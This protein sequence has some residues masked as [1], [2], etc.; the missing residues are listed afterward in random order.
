MVCCRIIHPDTA[1]VRR[2]TVAKPKQSRKK[3]RKASP[4]Q[5]QAA[6]SGKQPKPSPDGQQPSPADSKRPVLRFV[7]LFALVLVV[8]YGLLSIPFIE[9]QA[10]PAYLRVNAS[11][12]SAVLNVFGENSTAAG[13]SITSPRFSVDVRKGCDAI[14]PSAIFAAAVLASP[15]IFRTKVPGLVVGVLLLALLNFVR[16]VSLYFVGVHFRRAFEF[17]HVEFWQAVFILLALFLWVV[18]VLWALRKGAQAGG[19]PAA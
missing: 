16:I 18:W 9:D 12:A 7:G 13:T 15:V 3:K 8:S 1:H 14:A 19:S 11:A 2:Q 6:T 10:V 5:G 17:M 4:G